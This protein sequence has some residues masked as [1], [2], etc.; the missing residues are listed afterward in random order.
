MKKL[1][2]EN[3]AAILIALFVLLIVIAV[4]TV[5][6]TAAM[7]NS[8]RIENREEESR[9]YLA[10]QSA[11]DVLCTD[12]DNNLLCAFYSSKD[13]APSNWG[14]L[15]QAPFAVYFWNI[16]TDVLKGNK[17]AVE[18]DVETGKTFNINVTNTNDGSDPFSGIFV[19][20][21][22]YS[23]ADP[24]ECPADTDSKISEN[25]NMRCV[26]RASYNEDMSDCY[27][28]SFKL[29]PDCTFLKAA[30]TEKITQIAVNWMVRSVAKGDGADT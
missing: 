11:A 16:T 7:T 2:N 15:K 8:G 20:A 4:T 19:T 10:A 29:E 26:V 23:M 13:W 25:L 9:L 17:E 30:G 3:G 21:T 12:W 5:I 1:K 14:D 22:I 27:A 18:R 6:I 24:A 28:I